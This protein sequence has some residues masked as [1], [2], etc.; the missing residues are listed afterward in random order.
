MKKVIIALASLMVAVAAYAQGT[1][2]FNNRITGVVDARVMLPDGKG[3]GAG[4]TAEL[5]GGP[6]N[7]P[8]AQLKPLTPTTTFRATSDAAM[9][10]VNG[11]TVEVPGVTPGG[12]ATILMRAFNGSSFDSST[13]RGQSPAFQVTGLGG[14]PAGGAPLPP[15]NLSGLG[16]GTTIPLT[17]IPE[18]TTIAL[19]VLGVAA[20]L[21]RR[22]K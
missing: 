20:L 9:G 3:A 2:N 14:T 21:L 17:V 7:T 4:F 10:Y 19:G 5:L 1:V 15:A 16:I 6:A 11:V 12:A 8:A 13:I 22:R 18:P